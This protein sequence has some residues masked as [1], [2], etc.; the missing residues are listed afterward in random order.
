M[1]NTKKIKGFKR[2]KYRS[3]NKSKQNRNS[4]RTNRMPNVGFLNG[5]D[6]GMNMKH[7]YTYI[8]K[9]QRKIAEAKRN[10][11]FYFEEIASNLV[12]NEYAM[13]MAIQTVATN[14][15]YLS[16]SQTFDKKEHYREMLT[17]L[18]TTLKNPKLYKVSVLDR[19]YFPSK[20]RQKPIPIPSYKD[21]CL[22][23]LYKLALE[24]YSEE[25]ADEHNYGLPGRSPIWAIG[26]IYN[27][28]K[29]SK[30]RFA[31]TIDI[32]NCFDTI[33]HD[34][35][36]L[37]TPIIPK[38]IL[39]QW[40]KCG[41]IQRV[42]KEYLPY[43]ISPLLTNLILDGIEIYLKKYINQHSNQT[44]IQMIR[45]GDD[46]LILT[47]SLSNC[48]LAIHATK[49]FLKPK[50]LNLTL[51]KT[52]ITDTQYEDFEYLGYKFSTKYHKNR[53]EKVVYL[54]IPLDAIKTFR[55]TIRHITKKDSSQF[56]IAI[57]KANPI[58]RDWS[59]YYRHAHNCNKVFNHLEWW[60]WVQFFRLGKRLLRYQ[61]DKIKIQELTDKTIHTFF[62]SHKKT[63]RWPVGKVDDKHIPLF[64]ISE[65]KFTPALDPLKRANPMIPKF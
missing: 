14:K 46:L 43:E 34:Y 29:F 38:Y 39:K 32:R 4:K 41:Y 22:Q 21:R 13:A 26:R 16:K 57:L 40:V 24:P 27:L 11:N 55:K 63:T 44:A 3:L 33:D 49:E 6:V 31:L 30:Y 47:Q 56:T 12:K 1:S 35:L 48:Q 65:V 17:T 42:E 37:I 60:L 25:V 2:G 51:Q 58:L 5:F 50:G 10:G 15:D 59:N 61:Y 52:N 64:L 9:E 8:L 20:A 53:N 18:K 7:A 23:A 45:F 19:Q 36:T 28:L 54:T 62:K